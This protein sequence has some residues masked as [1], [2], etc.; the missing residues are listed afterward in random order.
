MNLYDIPFFIS[1]F[2]PHGGRNCYPGRTIFISDVE[3]GSGAP[4]IAKIIN[5]NVYVRGKYSRY[6]AWWILCRRDVSVPL[7]RWKQFAGNKFLRLHG[8]KA[9]SLKARLATLAVVIRRRS[10]FTRRV[11]RPFS[12]RKQRNF[13]FKLLF[14]RISPL[15]SFAWLHGIGRSEGVEKSVPECDQCHLTKTRRISWSRN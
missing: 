1:T 14:S 13:K 4:T 8:F 2:L 9:V 10:N 7:L 11:Y 12:R 5:K 3:E 15:V 6:S